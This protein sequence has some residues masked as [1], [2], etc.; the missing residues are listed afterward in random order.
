MGWPRVSRL[1]FPWWDPWASSQRE[2][3]HLGLP[4][5]ELEEVSGERDVWASLQSL[6][7]LEPGTVLCSNRRPPQLS[8][9]DTPLHPFSQQRPEN[10]NYRLTVWDHRFLLWSVCSDENLEKVLLLHFS[11]Q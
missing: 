11:C 6:L 1:G 4:S 3:E 9:T 8:N 10:Y 5:E 7:P 2:R